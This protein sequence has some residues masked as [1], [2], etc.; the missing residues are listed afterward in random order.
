MV[1]NS[2][3]YEFMQDQLHNTRLE[4]SRLKVKVTK[5]NREKLKAEA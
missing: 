4:N 2:K 5:L 1:V 3:T